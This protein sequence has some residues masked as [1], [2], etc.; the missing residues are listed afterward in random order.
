MRRPEVLVWR[1]DAL[2]RIKTVLYGL[3]QNRR[4]Q[5]RKVVSNKTL[6]IEM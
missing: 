1:R 4:S 2:K 6:F 3:K 5:T